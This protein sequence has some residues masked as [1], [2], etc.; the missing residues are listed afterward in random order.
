MSE[1]AALTGQAQQAVS[2]LVQNLQR[3]VSQAVDQAARDIGSGFADLVID[4][5]DT[6]VQSFRQS[7]PAI[8]ETVST[9]VGFKDSVETTVG[10][11]TG[12]VEQVQQA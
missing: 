1:V 4:Q 7:N 2:G 5:V 10:A 6:M 8:A 12:M 11:V 3:S 9:V